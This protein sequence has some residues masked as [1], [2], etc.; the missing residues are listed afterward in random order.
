MGEDR[1][2][3]ADSND[4]AS[5]KYDALDNIDASELAVLVNGYDAASVC[6]IFNIIY[7]S[8]NKNININIYI[9]AYI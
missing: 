2:T 8:I 6:D 7:I 5:I 4:A 3:A 1:G 9:Y